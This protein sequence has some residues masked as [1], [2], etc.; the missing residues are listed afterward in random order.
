MEKIY[1]FLG[2]YKEQVIVYLLAGLF[3]ICDLI[4]KFIILKSG[5]LLFKKE[6]IKNFFYL[7][8][9]K[10]T[11]AAF[12]ILEGAKMFFIILAFIVLFFIHKYLLK[13]KLNTLKIISYS[14]LVGGICGNLYDRIFYSYVVDFLSF[15]FGSYYFPVFNFADTFIVLGVIIMFID[16]FVGGYNEVRSKRK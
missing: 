12:S 5:D 2:R 11:G 4:S 8:L 14:M 10:N 1:N 3:F 9:Q 13:E 16:I 7:D 6:I 15:K